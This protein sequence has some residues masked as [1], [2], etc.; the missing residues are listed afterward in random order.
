MKPAESVGRYDSEVRLYTNYAIKNIKT[1][2]KNFGPRPVGSEAEINAQEYLAKELETT[3]DTVL[4]EEY[5]CSDKAFMSWVPIGAVAIIL[6]TVFFT[7]G[8][9]VVSLAAGCVTLFLILAEFIFYKPV[10]DIFFPKKT[11]MNVTGI[12][13]ASGETKR[14]IIFSG[15]VDSAFE[16]TY[17]Y[18]GG[19]PVVAG[20]IVT[21]VI[22]VLLSIGGGI[23][24][25][26]AGNGFVWTGDNL[27]IKI[28]TG[29]MYVTVPV[30][31]AAIFFCNYKRP[32][33]GAND[34]LSGCMVSAAVLKF[35][36]ANNI[37]FENTEVVVLMAGGEEAGLRGSKAWAKAHA[38]EMKA[39][40]VETVFVALDTIREID[41]MAI[42]DK[43]MTG[44]VKNDKR[45]AA[46]L[47]QAAKNAGHDVPVKAI[48][49]GST[50]AAAMSQ[51]GIPASA[52][53][54]M[55]PSPARYYHTRLDTE[56]NLDPKM[57][58]TG[59]KIALETAF[60]FDE[61]GI[62]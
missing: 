60:L 26:I 49:L 38:D 45:V 2:C 8:L 28:I 40:G 52:F 29:V 6:S 58:E 62:S 34:D 15:H 18:H 27:A 56:D 41:F 35:M 31:V 57:L 22:A 1:M 19:R 21:A 30:M 4:K 39:D 23:Y 16:W 46:L 61:Q 32:V 44:M 33:T 3:C 48:E 50:D 25:V 43:D 7:L 14:R 11:S 9:P 13:K 17:T 47:Q 51:A 24:G 20:I 42:Y 54:A 12:R 59:L 55:D 53:T 10:L 37:R 36:E 5:K